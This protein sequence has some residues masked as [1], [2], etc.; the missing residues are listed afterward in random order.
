M[1]RLPALREGRDRRH[2]PITW[3]RSSWLKPALFAFAVT[4]VAAFAIYTY[5]VIRALRQDAQRVAEIYA[6]SILPRWLAD[7]TLSSRELG[8]LFDLIREMP[9]AVIVT[10]EVGVPQLWKG[11][12]VPD[13]ARSEAALRLVREMAIDMDT[14]ARPR[15]VVVPLGDNT[16]FRWTIHV[17]ESSFLRRVAWMP[18]IATIVTLLFTVL[19]LWAYR[20]LKAVEQQAIWV[21]VAR[22]TAHQLGTPLS[23]IS[24]WLEIL[25]EEGMK[26]DGRR[27]RSDTVVEEMSHDLDRLRRIAQRFGQIGAP[28]ELQPERIAPVLDET[29]AYVRARMGRD[30]A[31]E[32]HYAADEAI[33]LNRE[34]F[35]WAFENLLKNSLDAFGRTQDHPVIRVRTERQGHWLRVVV[36]DNGRGISP[37]DLRR[38]FLPGYSTKKRGWG[39]GLTFV[40]RIIEDYHG[41]RISAYSAGQD[42]GMAIEMRL[43]IPR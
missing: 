35:G 32:R 7:P 27:R 9:V 38:I 17:A 43:P 8:V 10:D 37:K 18:F 12:S 4:V 15:E 11:I 25:Q 13:T 41:G 31:I 19:V 28:P 6:Q 36:E 5:T 30:V 33:P 23:S 21:G 14:H 3:V 26:E 16:A 24:G 39:L 29:I 1:M 22:E 20:E 34:L 2:M 40:K 42:Q